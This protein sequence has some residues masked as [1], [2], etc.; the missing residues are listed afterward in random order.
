M[1][2]AGSIL[3]YI[4]HRKGM[5]WPDREQLKNAAIS[6]ILLFLGGHTIV[7]W[8]EQ[9]VDSGI[10]ALVV[11]TMPLWIMVFEWLGP[12]KT[13]PR[14]AQMLGLVA[15]FAGIMIISG[16]TPYSNSANVDTGS[17]LILLLSPIM[18]AAGSLWMRYHPYQGS[19]M[20]GAA[21]QLLSG[22]LAILL[23]AM[24][25]GDIS[26]IQIRAMDIKSI[27]SV[28]Y[29]IIFGSL[30]GFSA[31]NYLMNSVSPI[32]VSTY[33]F[34]NPVLALFL[35]SIIGHEVLTNDVKLAAVIIVGSVVLIS[36]PKWMARPRLATQKCNV[37]CSD[38]AET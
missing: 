14:I 9:T 29:L 37:S 10:A 25:M 12:H 17:L 36:L 6:G 5:P 7:A 23:V 24:L 19:L 15:G 1:L 11:A 26:G 33:T 35:G 30:V 8:A 4:A 32:L 20:M 28:L 16:I 2:L 3:F 34:V 22:G 18:W 21:L 13:V 27:Y 31:Y 38:Q